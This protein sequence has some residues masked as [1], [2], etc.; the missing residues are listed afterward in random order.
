MVV[1]SGDKVELLLNGK[2]KGFGEQSSRFLFTFKN[3]AWEAG[4]IKAVSY[5]ARGKKLAKPKR[6]QRAKPLRLKLTLHT[7]P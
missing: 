5:D 4:K 7:G 6:K 2:S 3:I 1:S